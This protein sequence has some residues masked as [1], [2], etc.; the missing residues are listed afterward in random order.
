MIR[1]LTLLSTVALIVGNMVGTSIYTLPAGLAKETG[2]FGLVAW[3]FVAL[4]YLFVA[5][6]YSRL[7]TRYPR[8][9]GPYVYARTAFGDLAGFTTVW[10]YW[11]STIIGNAAIVTGAVGYLV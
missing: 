8:T 9:G 6:V 5:I 7:G 11:V 1:G 4:G 2:P 10:S 3:A